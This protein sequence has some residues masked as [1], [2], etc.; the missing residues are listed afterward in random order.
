[1]AATTPRN[2]KA[3]RL[4]A[5]PTKA[6]VAAKS[7]K[8]RATAKGT[9]DGTKSQKKPTGKVQKPP[10]RKPWVPDYVKIESSAQ[11]GLQDKEI[12]ALSGISHQVFCSKKNELPELVEALAR[13][14]A[15]GTSMA[16]TAL[17]REIL[18]GD[19]N[20]TKFFLER[21]AGWKQKQVIESRNMEHLSTEELLALL[22]EADRES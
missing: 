15:K 20:A 11:L 9:Q 14:R 8:K 4:E 7:T 16:A 18:K 1:M 3:D 22:E 21:K 12:A 10:G 19:I 5:V 13:G 2:K 6:K 17:W